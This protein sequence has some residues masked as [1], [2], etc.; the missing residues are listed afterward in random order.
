MAKGISI[1]NIREGA[2]LLAMGGKRARSYE[3]AWQETSSSG[4]KKK[5]KEKKEGERGRTEAE[6]GRK[7]RKKKKRTEGKCK[8][9]VREKRRK[10]G[11]N[12]HTINI[13][14]TWEGKT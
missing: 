2:Y 9:Y 7:R 4:M 1:R 6:I 12:Q 5:G 11:Q 3:A 10:M 8:E 13:A 14:K